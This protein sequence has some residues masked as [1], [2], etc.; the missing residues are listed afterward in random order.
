MA[1]DRLLIDHRWFNGQ[2]GA[3]IYRHDQMEDALALSVAN[4][5]IKGIFALRNPEKLAALPCRVVDR[6]DK[7]AK[8]AV[9]P[10]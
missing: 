9:G 6:V 7:S 2:P 10:P 3:L 5:R 8:P 4:D 1:S